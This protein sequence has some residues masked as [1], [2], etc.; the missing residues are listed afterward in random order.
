M[1]LMLSVLFSLNAIGSNSHHKMPSKSVKVSEKKSAQDQSNSHG[2]FGKRCDYKFKKYCARVDFT[3]NPSRSY[4][5]DFKIFFTDIKTKKST[6]PSEEVYPYL[7]M[8]MGNGHEHGSEKVEIVKAKDHYLIK[9]VWFV[10]IGAWELYIALKK[11]DKEIEKVM[12]K[13][14][15]GK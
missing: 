7:W 12:R 14:E 3:K 4:S 8:K 5:S 6:M 9:N 10:M 13:V 15:I 1:F 11:G 2:D